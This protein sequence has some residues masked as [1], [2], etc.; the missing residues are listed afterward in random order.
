MAGGKREGA[1]RPKGGHN[2]RT[3]GAMHAGTN[4]LSP[5]DYMLDVLRDEGADRQMRMEAAKAAA[6]YVHAR[7]TNVD[8]SVSNAD[9]PVAELADE[10][11][12]RI[13]A[14]GSSG[15]AKTKDSQ[16][17]LADLRTDSLHRA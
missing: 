8:M 12:Q 16:E 17:R 11:L 6:P 2:R 4:G 3:L 15:T 14:T 5:L 1:G 7:L 9:K 13:A 10:E